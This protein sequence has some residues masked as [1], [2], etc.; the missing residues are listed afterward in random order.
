M[1]LHPEGSPEA[2]TK[3]ADRT[4]DFVWLDAGHFYE[5]VQADLRAW[6]PKLKD[7]GVIGGDDWLFPNVARAVRGAFEKDVEVRFHDN[8]AWWWHRRKHGR[9]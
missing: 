2:A 7:G 4:L 3:F 1:R 6:V 9:R 5:E 8:W